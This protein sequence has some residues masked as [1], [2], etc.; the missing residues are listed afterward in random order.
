VSEQVR[1]TPEGRAE[2]ISWE[3]FH[4]DCPHEWRIKDELDRLVSRNRCGDCVRAAVAQAVKEERER[5]VG[6]E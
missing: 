6:D 1:I 2:E 4:L 5:W 3:L